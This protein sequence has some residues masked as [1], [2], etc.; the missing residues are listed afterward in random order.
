MQIDDLYHNAHL[1]VAAIRV[2]EYQHGRQPSVDDVC[3]MLSL[4]IEQGLFLG[5]KLKEMGIVEEVASTAGVRLFIKNHLGIEDIPKNEKD[6]NLADELKQF[7]DSQKSIS[8][9]IASF[10]AKQVKKKKD[11]FADME[12]KLKS[13]LDKS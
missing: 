10:Q 4:S 2:W 8:S 12:K 6:T 13:E 7:K 11:L 3:G 9:E 5:R 1:Y